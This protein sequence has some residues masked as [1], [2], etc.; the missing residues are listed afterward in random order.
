MDSLSDGS[1]LSCGD[2]VSQLLALAYTSLS[3]RVFGY[4]RSRGV[5]DPE[6]ITHDVF[7][8]LHPLLKDL[9]G[10]ARGLRTLV[11]SIAHART[12]DQLRIQSRTT[13]TV[14]YEPE[15]DRRSSP[16]VDEVAFLAEHSP[17][18]L[19]LL[20]Q[21]VDDQR[22]VLRLRVIADL[23]IEQTAGIMERS[24]GAIKQLQH[25]A[26]SNLRARLAQTA[27]ERE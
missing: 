19:G 3:G 5:D 4:V 18:A 1:I 17:D 22:E 20:A 8:A 14:S 11:F 13:M 21:L 2:N 16:P 23:S 24:P 26:L 7:L 12:V 10:G 9:T 27:G 15:L 25:R 6:A